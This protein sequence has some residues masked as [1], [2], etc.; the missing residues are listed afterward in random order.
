MVL[1]LTFILQWYCVVSVGLSALHDIEV[2]NEKNIL[3][4][5]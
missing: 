1:Y 5:F 3:N 2:Q 4:H